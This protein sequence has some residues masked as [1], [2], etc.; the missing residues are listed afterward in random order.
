M[1]P[2]GIQEK[3]PA[4][5][6]DTAGLNRFGIISDLAKPFRDSPRTEHI[7]VAGWIQRKTGLCVAHQ[8][9]ISTEP[10]SEHLENQRLLESH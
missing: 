7:T 6:S 10:D 4:A 2:N 1:P 8:W 5:A 3:R 9:T